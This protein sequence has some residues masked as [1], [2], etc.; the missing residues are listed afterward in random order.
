MITIAKNAAGLVS[1]ARTGNKQ[2]DRIR[3]GVIYSA[4]GSA[5]SEWKKHRSYR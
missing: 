5:P 4:C 3:I 2:K 1:T